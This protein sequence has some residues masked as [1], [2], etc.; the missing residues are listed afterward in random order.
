MR[1]A[2]TM[3]LVVAV[4]VSLG[5]SASAQQSKQNEGSQTAKIA[6]TEKGFEPASIT[7]KPNV[8]ARVTFVRQ[9]DKTCATAVSIPEYKIERE[10]PLNEPVVV[11]FTPKKAGEFTFA[12]GMNMLKGTVVVKES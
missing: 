5:L 1:A 12:C 4:I 11:E 8:P 7:L 10:L 6:V 3:I 2:R 9:T